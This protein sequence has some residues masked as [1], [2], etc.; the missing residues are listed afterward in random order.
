MAA[1]SGLP[2]E[3]PLPSLPR[4]VI[5]RLG[6]RGVHRDRADPTP[7]ARADRAELEAVAGEGERAR[8]VAVACILRQLRQRVDADL[9]HALRLRGLGA[10]AL[11]LLEHVGQLLAEE[12]RDDRRRG[13]VGAQAVV[14]AGRRDGGAQHARVL[15]HGADHRAAE[16]QE[17]RVLV[18]RVARIE[19]VAL[20]GV[21]DRPVD[22]LA[23]AVDAGE[24]L[25]VQ[26]ADHAVLLG[27]ALAA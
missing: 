25:L 26:Q 3:S 19:Q 10:A 21:A 7:T 24:R 5:E 17:L 23:R 16:H 27:H 14:V 4:D 12:D 8:A 11:D 20:R 9:Q 1:L 15:V 22:V 2:P 13:F 18:R 6:Q